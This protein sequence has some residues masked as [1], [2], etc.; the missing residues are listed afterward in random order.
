[1]V[2]QNQGEQRMAEA[3]TEKEDF[4]NIGGKTGGTEYPGSIRKQKDCNH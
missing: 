1:M 3:K 4:I 2:N